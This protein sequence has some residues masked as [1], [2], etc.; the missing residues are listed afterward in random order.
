MAYRSQAVT[1]QASRGFRRRTMVSL[2]ASNTVRME[3]RILSLEYVE[4]KVYISLKFLI[5]IR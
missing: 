5:E 1:D 3:V 4:P 2:P